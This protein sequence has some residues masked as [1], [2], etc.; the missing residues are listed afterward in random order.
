MAVAAGRTWW[1]PREITFDAYHRIFND[2]RIW[3]GYFNTVWYVIVGTSVN[4]IL[5]STMAYALSRKHFAPRNIIMMVVVFT[6]FFSGGLIPYFLL[7]RDLGLLDTRWVIVFNGAVNVMNL[8]IMRTFFQELPQELFDS[9][10]IDGCNDALIFI[11]IVLPLSGAVI[12]VISLYYAVAHWNS[13]FPALIFLNSE[14]LMPLQILLRRILIM[15]DTQGSTFVDM[16][17]S[18]Q[19]TIRY[20]LIIVASL[21]IICLYPFLQRFFVKGVM[22]G[23]VKG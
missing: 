2:P 9:A 8:I 5:T 7:I 23:A 3:Q 12:A 15:L 14:D 22:I 16:L 4:L 18:V 1:I 13:F 10:K 20:A 6:M 11:K 21:P 19:H 17:D